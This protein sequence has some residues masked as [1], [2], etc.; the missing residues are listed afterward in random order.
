M[1]HKDGVKKKN[2]TASLLQ[3]ATAD[4]FFVVEFLLTA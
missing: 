2:V 4:L 3:K 1:E